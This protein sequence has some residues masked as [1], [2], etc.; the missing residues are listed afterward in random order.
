MSRH[1]WHRLTPS[2]GHRR[3]MAAE[4]GEAAALLGRA[5]HTADPGKVRAWLRG[6]T[7]LVTG[8]GGSIG[9]ELCRQCALYGARRLLLVEIDELALLQVQER[10]HAAF[11]ALECVAVLG[12]CGD[13]AVLAHALGQGPVETLIHAAAYKHVP[14]LEAQPRE[15]ARNNVLATAAVAQAARV[16][17]IA[18]MVLVSTDKAVDPVSVLGASKRLAEQACLAL[19]AQAP[20]TRLAVVRFGNVLDSAG[21]VTQVFREQIRR[22]GPLTLT[23]PQA[24]R[25][26]MTIPEAC[27]LILQA[28]ALG[29]QRAMYALDMGAPVAILTLASR[30]L[31]QAG[32]QPQEVGMVFTGLRPGERLHEPALPPQRQQAA[33]GIWRLPLDAAVPAFFATWLEALREAVLSYDVPALQRLLRE[34]APADSHAPQYPRDSRDSNDRAHR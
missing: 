21:S 24:T 32:L 4:P 23:H 16:A 27:Q 15:A 22:G 10:L 34:T 5:E 6:Q 31:R 3:R 18:C 33:P 26:F 29:E 20:A 17:G 25:Y 7:V 28:A 11:P 2:R 19:L 30:L 13:P 9:A 12:D 1:W 8:A 14:L